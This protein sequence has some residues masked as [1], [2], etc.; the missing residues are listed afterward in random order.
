MYVSSMHIPLNF[1]MQMSMH[2][3]IDVS[4]ANGYVH[5]YMHANFHGYIRVDISMN[6]SIN[7]AMDIYM[8]VAMDV[9]NSYVDRGWGGVAVRRS[10]RRGEGVRQSGSM[11]GG[12]V[13]GRSSW[14]R[15]KQEVIVGSV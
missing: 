7:M 8:R 13:A 14:F 4:T 9:S 6:I 5:G 11:W 2:I 15:R 12:R 1:S 10:V 3:S